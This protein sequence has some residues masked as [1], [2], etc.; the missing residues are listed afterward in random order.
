MSVERKFI[1]GT[2]TP[3]ADDAN[4]LGYFVKGVATK[5]VELSGG[6]LELAKVDT[7]TTSKY[8]AY[9]LIKGTNAGL[10]VGTTSSYSRLQIGACAKT[11]E[12]TFVALGS[13]TYFNATGTIPVDIVIGAIGDFF[14]SVKFTHNG[15]TMECYFGWGNCSGVNNEVLAFGNT[16]S[17]R[18]FSD[19]TASTDL[20]FAGDGYTS[21]K[22]GT[23]GEKQLNIKFYEMAANN[24]SYSLCCYSKYVWEST[25]YPGYVKWGGLYDMYVLC[26]AGA[27]FKV[28]TGRKYLLD[29]KEYVATN[30]YLLIPVIAGT[31]TIA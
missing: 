15:S 13:N 20:Y 14:C 29:G 5:M 1:E 19:Y 9:Y 23:V 31:T 7:E 24:C 8:Y 28:T 17:P 12:N 2:Y 6:L 30:E 18:Q 11:G 25:V 26:N 16:G 22:R 10:Y 27:E 21:S 3:T 4:N